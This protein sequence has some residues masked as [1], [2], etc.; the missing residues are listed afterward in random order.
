MAEFNRTSL[1]IMD[2]LYAPYKEAQAQ[3]HGLE[4]QAGDAALARGLQLTDAATKRGQQL[5]DATTAHQRG[6]DRITHQIESADEVASNQRAD[7]KKEQTKE[8][9]Q[10]VAAI[11]KNVSKLV[12]VNVPVTAAEINNATPGELKYFKR[13][14]QSEE[15]VAKANLKTHREVLEKLRAIDEDVLKEVYFGGDEEDYKDK[16]LPWDELEL[17]SK[18]ELAEILADATREKAIRKFGPTVKPLYR[19]LR[20]LQ[21][22]LMEKSGI[23]DVISN[24]PNQGSVEAAKAIAGDEKFMVALFS[25]LQNDNWFAGS[26]VPDKGK[27]IIGLLEEG[28]LQE[29]ALK[30]ESEEIG[31][32]A[33]VEA[34]T[35]WTAKSQSAL[36]TKIQ[37]KLIRM[38]GG[39]EKLRAVGQELDGLITRHPWLEQ[40]VDVT[41]LFTAEGFKEYSNRRAAARTPTAPDADPGGL[42]SLYPPQNNQAAPVAPLSEIESE[43]DRVNNIAP[44]VAPAPS[45][46]VAAPE[47]EV[48]SL[49]RFDRNGDGTLDAYEKLLKAD[50]EEGLVSGRAGG[51]LDGGTISPDKRSWAGRRLALKSL[52]LDKAGNYLFPR[53]MAGEQQASLVERLWRHDPDADYWG[54]LN[55]YAPG[56]AP[57]DVQAG[58]GDVVLEFGGMLAD[59]WLAAGGLR[60]LWNSPVALGRVKALVSPS[61]LGVGAFGRTP[62]ASQAIHVKELAKALGGGAALESFKAFVRTPANIKEAVRRIGQ[63]GMRYA[64]G[65]APKVIPKSRRL[66]FTPEKRGHSIITPSRG[67]TPASPPLDLDN[68]KPSKELLQGTGL[69]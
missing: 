69:Y 47:V 64:P 68:L 56:D 7:L 46:P 57:S 28:R 49:G 53:H 34:M 37:D 58:A 16:V 15:E 6:L 26:N 60:L 19:R 48:P 3:K 5:T 25:S 11:F 24:E 1:D 12:G 59:A 29:A 55:S 35:R 38:Q 62:A 43:I 9:R 51:A 22:D 4:R 30:M 8:D 54:L 39:G 67:H 13:I 2:E 36:A 32:N 61:G 45:P 18:S 52:Q 50:E 21:I 41:D 17:E 14:L 42:G 27:H 20:K 10:E 65:S 40:S 33:L 31:S 66:M 23:L 44:T 63:S